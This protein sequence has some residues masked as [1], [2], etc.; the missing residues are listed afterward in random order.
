MK[1]TPLIAVVVLG[2]LVSGCSSS[3]SSEAVVPN[4][5]AAVETAVPIDA[6]AQ[7]EVAAADNE[8]AE[9]LRLKVSYESW[10]AGYFD[11]Y[12]EG[13]RYLEPTPHAEDWSASDRTAYD[14]GYTVGLND[15]EIGEFYGYSGV[16]E[17][18][19]AWFAHQFG[20][21]G[22]GEEIGCALV[23]CEGR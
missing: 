7:A 4:A 18:A 9:A 23:G 2:L 11:G 12:H 22:W 6:E 5:P 17:Y 8:A 15:G 14:E 19:D 3:D 10:E 20:G 16:S 13:N 21:E 1:L